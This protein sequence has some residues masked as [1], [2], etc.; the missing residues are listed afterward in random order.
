MSSSFVLLSYRTWRV[1]VTG[2]C[3]YATILDAYKMQVFDATG[4]TSCAA[5]TV[6][7]EEELNSLLTATGQ[8]I[9]TICKNLY[10]KAEVTP[11][12]DAAGKGKDYKFE[13]AFYNGHSKWQEEVETTYET[14]D[15]T[16]TS[17]LREDAANVKA[18]Y[19][20]AGSYTRV[21]ELPLENFQ[22]CDSNAAM[23]CWPKDRQA[24]DNNGNCA[25]N[26]YTDNCVNKDPADNTNACV[27]DLAKGSFATNFVSNDG[28]IELP[29]DGDEGE[30]AIHCHGYAWAND[31]YDPTN[32]YKYNNL[33]YVSMYDHMHQRGYVQNIPGAPMCACVEK[34]PIVTRSDCTQVDLT[35]EYTVTFDGVSVEAKMTKV[36]VDFNAC[37][38][39]NRRN[40][41]L[42]AYAHKLYEEE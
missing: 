20:G 3:D 38:G 8:D 25:S 13:E 11:F 16:A 9:D 18:F 19:Q 41:D 30:G 26:L 21:S 6:T 24:N 34:M 14:L 7:A 27:V 12:Y 33:F 28:I 23:C 4:S 1:E 35:E 31:E 37:Q 22:Q 15:A 2:T 32:R 42:Y 39:K 10:D 29:G 36:E 5:G 17:V 40:N